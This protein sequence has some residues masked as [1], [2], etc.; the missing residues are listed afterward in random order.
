MTLFPFNHYGLTTNKFSSDIVR[1]LSKRNRVSVGRCA[2]FVG[3]V[4]CPTVISHPE[5]V[6][7]LVH[8]ASAKDNLVLF[9]LWGRESMLKGKTSESIL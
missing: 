1:T 4:R 2:K 5:P 9:H 3:H 8:S 6:R 7:Q